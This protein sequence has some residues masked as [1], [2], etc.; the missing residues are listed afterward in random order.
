MAPDKTD[1]EILAQK[2]LNVADFGPG[3]MH[4]LYRRA[5]PPR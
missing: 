5:G 4:V 2:A 3:I 1:T